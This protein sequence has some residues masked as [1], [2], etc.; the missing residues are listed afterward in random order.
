PKKPKAVVAPKKT[1]APPV[2][3]RPPLPVV[4]PVPAAPPAP[5]PLAKTSGESPDVWRP[6]PLQAPLPLEWRGNN[7]TSIKHSGQIVVKKHHQW[8]RFWAEHHPDEVA[9]DVDFSQNM[10]VG[11]F[12]GRR[13]A[14]AFRVDITGARTTR[15][16]L[17]V[18]YIE[19]APP[20][21]T[22]QV[23]VEVYPYDIKV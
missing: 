15:D 12:V 10:V 23:A 3:M 7:D 21:G 9:P 11:V 4:P 5:L 13:P 22:F 17:V 16:A 19:R 14:D 1:V 8:I 6:Q 20:P 2:Q 18:D